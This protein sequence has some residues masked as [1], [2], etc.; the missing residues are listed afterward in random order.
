VSERTALY[1]LFDA[2]GVLLYVGISKEFGTRWHQHARSQPWWGEVHH[3]TIE[4]HESRA[5]AEAAEETA[6]RM[7][8][9]HAAQRDSRHNEAVPR[10]Q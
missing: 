8:F 1:R 2:E 9:R 6:I 5:D 4:W 7:D 10:R 3:Q